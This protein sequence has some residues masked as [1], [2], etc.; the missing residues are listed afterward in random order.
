MKVGLQTWGTDGDFFPFLALAIG[1][2]QA[3]HEVILAYT[4]VDGKDY[5][6][7]AD[8]A[9]IKLIRANGNVRIP[10]QFNP[11][12]INARPGS[13]REYTTLLDR[14]FEP[15]TEAMFHASVELCRQCDVVV[16]HAVCYTLVTASQKF[17][18]RRVSLVLT[19]IIV[20]SAHT[21]P[22]GIDLGA[23]INSFLW[24]A[25]GIISTALWFKKSKA[26]RKKEGLG[27]IKSLQ[28][29][30]FTSSALTLVAASE[31]LCARPEDWS[32]TVK[33]TGF[34]NLPTTSN[35]SHLPEELRVFLKN[36]EPPVYM[37]FGSCLQF[38]LEH[39]T[40]LLVEAAK[41]SGKRAIIQSD[42]SRVQKPDDSNIFCIDR[43]PHAEIFPH[44]SMVVHHGG[45][46]TTQAALLAEKPSVVVPHGFDQVY[47]ANQVSGQNLGGKPLKKEK[48][49]AQ[50]LAKEINTVLSNE[51][52]KANASIVGKKMRKEDGVSE[53]IGWIEK[54]HI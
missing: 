26:I 10:G 17:S 30:V 51:K 28:K 5:S 16:G 18:V 31:W 24:S 23:A 47:W 25:G 52:L 3:G 35:V 4:S 48:L 11:Y 32:Q 37:T 42:W 44:C 21:S 41:L 6:N 46:G 12:A 13:F 8:V 54:L 34:L 22:I 49:S 27:A 36:G 14:W 20:R 7:R 43:V 2:T 40:E 15:F 45:A 39:S 9:G 38:D 33:V 19:P 1:L 50:V 29:E 53:A